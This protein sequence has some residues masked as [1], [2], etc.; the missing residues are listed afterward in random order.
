MIQISSFYMQNFHSSGTRLFYLWVF[1]LLLQI[2]EIKFS[3][4]HIIEKEGRKACYVR[5]GKKPHNLDSI[6]YI[7]I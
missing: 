6:N 7:Y 3:R 2:I 5:S 4:C 1:A